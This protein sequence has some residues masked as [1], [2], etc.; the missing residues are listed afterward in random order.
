MVNFFFLDLDPKKCSEYYCN[1]HVNK[2]FIE[3]CQLLCNVLHYNTN[4]KPPYKKCKNISKNL[5]PFKWASESKGN[6]LYLL[7]L[8]QNLLNEY[9]Y[10]YD[11]ENH[12]SE[13]VLI[14]LKNIIYLIFLRRKND[15]INLY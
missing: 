2:I 4:L 10:R 3:I 12:K 7:E 5:A 9:K 11:K 13:I 6:Y 8:A 1:K 14:W 15:K